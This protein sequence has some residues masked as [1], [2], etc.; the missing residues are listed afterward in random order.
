MTEPPEEAKRFIER[1]T[2]LRGSI[3]GSFAQV[4]YYLGDL[5]HQGLRMPEYAETARFCR[6]VKDRLEVA[7]ALAR[8][9]GALESYSSGI[10]GICTTLAAVE[11]YRNYFTHGWLEVRASSQPDTPRYHLQFRKWDPAKPHHPIYLRV[12]MDWLEELDGRA[13]AMAVIAGSLF[14]EI[15]S[16]LALPDPLFE[17][18]AG[19]TMINPAF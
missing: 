13:M 6:T 12:S 5:G 18:T 3:V 19:D 1:A 2:Y 8:G 10:E 14:R 7:R 9:P 16:N 17:R 11:P 15:Y 4:E